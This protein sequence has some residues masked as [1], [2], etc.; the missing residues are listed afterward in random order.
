MH[1]SVVF[2]HIASLFGFHFENFGNKANLTHPMGN[3]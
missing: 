3:K 2:F 1:N